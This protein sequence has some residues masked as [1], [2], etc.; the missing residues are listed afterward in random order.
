M[1]PT[2][3]ISGPKRFSGL[4]Y[5]AKRPV[6][7]NAQPTSGPNTA[8]RA[9]VRDVLVAERE[10][11]RNEARHEPGEAERPQRAAEADHRRSAS[12]ASPDS[13]ALATKPSAPLSSARL[14]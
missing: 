5:Q 8:T 9:A 11:Q 6:P 4:R 1:K 10:K 12:S 7:M 13:S 14:P 2:A 3:V